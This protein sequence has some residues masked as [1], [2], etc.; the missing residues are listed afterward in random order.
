MESWEHLQEVASNLPAYNAEAD[1]GLLLGL[2]CGPAIKPKETVTGA[3]SEP[4]AV[5]TELGW[6]VVGIVKGSTPPDTAC[7]LVNMGDSTTVRHY[8]YRTQVKEITPDQ[9]SRLFDSDFREDPRDV[10]VS[11]Q[12]RRFEKL[13]E[14]QMVQREDG[15][16][17]APLPL[18]DPSFSFQNNRVMAEQRLHS[19]KRR[20]FSNQ[21]LKEE[22]QTYMEDMLDRGYAEVVPE[23]ELRRDDGKVWYVP[24]HGV[25][26]QTKEKL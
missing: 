21:R 18:K 4:W 26:S 15:H 2:N 16:F 25:Y 22:Y 17:I 3:D 8:A 13:M 7:Y 24:H 20:M 5:R 1:I 23:D 10:K 11:Q 19:L 6:C 9:V 12:D 14:E